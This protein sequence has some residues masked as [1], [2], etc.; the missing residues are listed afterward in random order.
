[1]N[2]ILSGPPGTFEDPE[3]RLTGEGKPGRHLKLTSLDELPR[4]AVRGWPHRRR[5]GPRK[6]DADQKVSKTVLIPRWIHPCTALLLCARLSEGKSGK[7]RY[8]AGWAG[9]TLVR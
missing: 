5:G 2:L 3:R 7:E 9:H 8:T 4:D 6:V 1:V